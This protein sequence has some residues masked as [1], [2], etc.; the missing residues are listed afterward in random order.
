MI[1]I[2]DLT[3]ARGSKRLLEAASLAVHVGHKVGIVGANGC[4]KSSLFAAIRGEL[5]PDAGAIELPPKWTLA[6]VAQETP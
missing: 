1:R 3:L 4:G 5:L 2:C 6:H